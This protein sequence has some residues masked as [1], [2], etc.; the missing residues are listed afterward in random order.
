MPP[1]CQA[2]SIPR[3]LAWAAEWQTKNLF[4]DVIEQFNGYVASIDS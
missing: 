1:T 3:V 2:L 4:Y